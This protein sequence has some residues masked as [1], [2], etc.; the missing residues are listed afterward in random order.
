[1]SMAAMNLTSMP[2]LA[3]LLRGMVA[4]PAIPVADIASDSRQLKP[5][6][7][8]F[9]C[10]GATSHALQFLDKQAAQSLAALVWDGDESVTPP[11][12]VPAIVVPDLKSQLPTIAN[13]FFATPSAAMQVTGVTGTNGKTTVAWLLAQAWQQL[14]QRCAYIGTLGA[15]LDEVA[16]TQGLTTPD[17]IE[18]QRQLA[19]FRDAQAVRVALEV[20]SHGLQQQRVAGTEFAT[21]IFT[22]LSRDHIDFHGTMAAYGATKARLFTEFAPRH[23][24]I[25]IDSEYGRTLAASCGSDA[26]LVATSAGQDWRGA[27]YVN[28]SS[29]KATENGATLA[30]DSSWGGATFELPLVGLFN[31]ANALL[32][33]AALLAD[34]VEFADA[35]E[36]MQTL[37]APA[38][39]M[40]PV[41]IQSAVALPAVY[42][43]YA[44]T[45]AA[46]EAALSA[47]RP[48]CRGK[49]WC[50]FGCG[51]DRDRGKRP[52]MGR[53]VVENADCAVLTSD[54]P[55]SESPVA[56]MRDVQNGVDRELTAIEDRAAAIA[57]TIAH[58]AAHDVVLIA[59]KGHEDYQ[60]VADRRLDFS[61]YQAAA[62]NLRRRQ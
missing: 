44:H 19:G 9:A 38:G 59:G 15:G 10:R 57:W 20:S 52:L 26:I 39:R 4:A 58:A 12:G 36:V 55:R 50:V 34:E 23:K 31:V 25:C 22:N 48:H 53:A 41:R 17:S 43:D 33:L 8:F 24:I 60:L 37:S 28:A 3:D 62:E 13:R 1:M 14:G 18:L 46:L 42:V 47:L 6:A 49:L 51:G 21:A 56:I 35:L 16:A 27:R 29:I 61:D 40:Q 54:N 11:T 45:P 7:V 2:T 30:I 5:G 32:V